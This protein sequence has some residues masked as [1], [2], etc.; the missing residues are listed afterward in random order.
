M[1][2]GYLREVMARTAHT[3]NFRLV[4]PDETESNRLG[5]VLE[6]TAR[7]WMAE[8]SPLDEELAPGGRG[9]SSSPSTRARGG[10]RAIC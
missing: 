6:V 8:R 7:E 4:G 5:A 2:G 3:R 1:L 10:S 9:S